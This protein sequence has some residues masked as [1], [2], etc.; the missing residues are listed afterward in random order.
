M[1]HDAATSNL[2]SHPEWVAGRRL[3]IDGAMREVIRKIQ[4]GDPVRGWEGDPYLAVYWDQPNARWELW[5]E[6]FDGEHRKVCQSAPGVPFDERLIDELVSWDQRRRAID[7]HA[8]IGAHNERVDAER[9]RP[10]HEYLIEEAGPRLR[11][12]FKKD[13]AA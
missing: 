2:L 13:G 11:H 10:H 5:R 6:E 9:L 12:A 1:S 8:E 7:I 3:W 4:C